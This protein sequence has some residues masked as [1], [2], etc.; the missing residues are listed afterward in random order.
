MT[1][2]RVLSIISFTEKNEKKEIFSGV[3]QIWNLIR[4]HFPGSG[5]AY[6][7]LDPQQ[8]YVD[9]DG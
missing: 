5:S 9:P 6:P 4:I 8:N 2:K 7:D 1:K 3:V